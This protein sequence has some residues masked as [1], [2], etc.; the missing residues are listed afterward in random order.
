MD[1]G[2]KGDG[3]LFLGGGD[4]LDEPGGQRGGD[5][6]EEGDNSSSF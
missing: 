6:P 2:P 5:H 3:L 4:L 1:L